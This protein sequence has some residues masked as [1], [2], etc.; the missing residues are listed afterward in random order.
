MNQLTEMAAAI[1]IPNVFQMMTHFRTFTRMPT[2]KAGAPWL[3]N[4]FK[5][6]SSLSIFCRLPQ[7]VQ[8]NQDRTNLLSNLNN[9]LAS[10]ATFWKFRRLFLQPMLDQILALAK[11]KFLLIVPTSEEV[12][13]QNIT[14]LQTELHCFKKIKEKLNLASEPLTSVRLA[15][16]SMTVTRP[17]YIRCLFRIYEKGFSVSVS[18]DPSS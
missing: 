5:V 11:F 10:Q 7:Q 2:I 6:L 8:L 3:M 15:L 1:L 18:S 9:Y 12:L 14:C 16:E 17:N 13:W 4:G